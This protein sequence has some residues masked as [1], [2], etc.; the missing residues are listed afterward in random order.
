MR[1][2]K[3][4][5]FAVALATPFPV[6]AVNP[7]PRL[8][9]PRHSILDLCFKRLD[10]PDAAKFFSKNL[11]WELVC[12]LETL[13]SRVASREAKEWPPHVSLLVAHKLYEEYLR[14]RANFF[15]S[16]AEEKNYEDPEGFIWNPLLENRH[17][18]KDARKDLGP[19]ETPFGAFSAAS[20]QWMD[21]FDVLL[22]PQLRDPKNALF[23]KEAA[24][25][26]V[27]ILG[28]SGRMSELTTELEG[29]LAPLMN[30][31]SDRDFVLRTLFEFS[32]RRASDSAVLKPFLLKS[33]AYLKSLPRKSLE[34]GHLDLW[35]QYLTLQ[36]VPETRA[37]R[38]EV[39]KTLRELWILFP[40][41]SQKIQI[42]KL[43]IDLDVSQFFIGPSERQMKID[44]LLLHADQQIRL[45]VG[46][47]ALKTLAQVLRLPSQQYTPKELWDA[48][49]LH[50]RLL[51]ILDKRPLIPALLA[52]YVKKGHFLDIPATQIE[53][54]QFFS[55]LYQIGRWQW[56]YDTAEKALSTFD[57]IISLNRAWGTDF[58][59]A[60]SYYIRARIM[61]QSGDRKLARLYFEEAI[62]E[63][64]ERAKKNSDLYEDLLW[65]RF[66]NEYD[67][68]SENQNYV[69]LQELIEGIKP[70][71]LWDEDG[72]RWLFWR[73]MT[74]LSAGDKS[75]AIE[76]FKE[77]YRKAPLSYYSV[78]S[79][80]E[81]LKLEETPSD[82]KLPE[83]TSFWLSEEPW[84][85]PSFS[86]Y[87][88]VKTLKFKNSVDLPWAQVYGLASLGRFADAK[89]YLSNLEKRLYG[90]AGNKK[91]S[92]SHR[93]EALQRGAWLR[94]A[95]GDQIGSLRMGE[96]ARITFEGKLEAEDLAYL[97]PLPFKRLIEESARQRFLDPWHA[98]SLIRQESA[99]N[100]Q[101]RSSANALG[102]MQIIP[103]VAALEAE[104][105][106]IKNF[107]PEQLT[108]PTMSVRIGT[109]HLGELYTHFESSVIVSTAGYNA[110]RPP[111][112]SW[113]KHYSHPLPYVFVD[114]ISFAETR[115][116]V[117][118]IL[119]NYVNYARI[120]GGAKVD[121][122]ALLKM[123]V[124]MPGALVAGETQDRL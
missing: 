34:G 33:L 60:S 78:I 118:S 82:W 4:W 69:L 77:A 104:K 20:A 16:V 84:R 50:I 94:L 58:Q 55:R 28:S 93:R 124:L 91:N 123:P 27:Q 18:L 97:Y 19:Q 64:K 13:Q 105:L 111:V 51:R 106:G 122:D 52:R 86:D 37:Q 25:L 80:L 88:D 89:R 73:A 44:E 43:A 29:R 113:L 48:L 53:R 66:Y 72:E 92:L 68:A 1:A 102:L 76:D 40:L 103:P 12:P 119:R 7:G 26:R 99:F 59:L 121:A 110:G 116:Y 87:F 117:R 32:A 14:F 15:V 85:A 39:L 36:G 46:D 3:V 98:I 49:E 56:S 65:R 21:A 35:A 61:E 24:L 5:V 9:A 41:A 2:S 114:R 23:F 101:A 8:P 115:K 79:G 107:R 38:E 30:V 70:F 109:L 112:Y 17:H 6:S 42:R 45:L 100:P 54:D 57:R 71:V 63:L 11:E 47:D 22:E 10:E 83:A 108:D 81:L 31:S 120:Y 95:A 62:Q 75:A 90:L 74:R 67:Q 96:L